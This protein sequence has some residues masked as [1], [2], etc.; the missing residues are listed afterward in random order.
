MRRSY[1]VSDRPSTTFS[2][3]HMQ[4]TA[5]LSFRVTPPLKEALE[6]LAAADKRSLSS[7]IEM[8]LEAH[9]ERAEKN[10]KKR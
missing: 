3:N 10:T 8:A 6:R 1:I 7:Y 9:V 4:K 5:P 2:Y